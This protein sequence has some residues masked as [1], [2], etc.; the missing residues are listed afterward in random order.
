[1]PVADTLAQAVVIVHNGPIHANG[2]D[3][4]RTGSV[5]GGTVVGRDVVRGAHALAV[6][7]CD[8]RGAIGVTIIAR[9]TTPVLEGV[10]GAAAGCGVERTGVIAHLV[11]FSQCWPSW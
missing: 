1:M 6:F 10:A 5:L 3:V 4:A 11:Q 8:S 9:E 2:T 7:I